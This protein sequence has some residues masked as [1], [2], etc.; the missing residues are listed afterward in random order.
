MGTYNYINLRTDD[1]IVRTIN[2]FTLHGVSLFGC[3]NTYNSYNP[4][5]NCS[6]KEGYST[7][8]GYGNYASN[9]KMVELHGN[10][11]TV[12]NYNASS[13]NEIYYNVYAFGGNNNASYGYSGTLP[14]HDLCLFGKSNSSTNGTYNSGAFGLNNSME[15]TNNSCIFGISNSL[16]TN[17]IDTTQ[18]NIFVGKSNSGSYSHDNNIFGQNNSISNC[19]YSTALG[20][21]LNIDNNTQVIIGN[22]ND[23]SDDN[24]FELG[25]GTDN[26]H[27]HNVAVIT[28]TGDLILNDGDVINENGESLTTLRTDIDLLNGRVEDLEDAVDNIED[29]ID[30]L[31]S[32]VE[33]LGTTVDGLSDD[34]ESLDDTVDTLSG[35]VDALDIIVGNNERDITDLEGQVAQLTLSLADALARISELENIVINE[36]TNHVQLYTE[37]GD[38]RITEDGDNKFTEEVLS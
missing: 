4:S 14:I 2:D 5:K 21:Y 31:E 22:Y 11:N 23:N 1:A 15:A 17:G 19:G 12:G 33:D 36:K 32:T 26:D 38:T 30:S 27:R 3:T 24:Y 29:D 9:V 34:V 6:S 25:N 20:R 18:C 35:S 16:Y 13:E 8:I 7:L 10:N 28:R 37:D